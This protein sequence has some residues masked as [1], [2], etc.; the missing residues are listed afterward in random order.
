MRA[1]DLRS[2]LKRQLGQHDATVQF[3]LS[4]IAINYTELPPTLV[5]GICRLLRFTAGARQD[6]RYSRVADQIE[7]QTHEHAL[8]TTVRQTKDRLV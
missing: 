2:L 3:L 6:I 7:D 1:A 8:D 5:K 4:S